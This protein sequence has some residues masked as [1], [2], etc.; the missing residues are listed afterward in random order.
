MANKDLKKYEL[1]DEEL[2]QVLGGTRVGDQYE[3]P[4][5]HNTFDSQAELNE[6]MK[7][8]VSLYTGP[9]NSTVAPALHQYA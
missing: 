8:H 9:K 1:S 5:C 6:H 4:E 2:E 7:S 3:C